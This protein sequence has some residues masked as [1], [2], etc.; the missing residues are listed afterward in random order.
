MATVRDV[1]VKKLKFISETGKVFVVI[2]VV[3][4]NRMV[5]YSFMTL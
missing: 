3:A 2:D 5:Q 4:Y 1:K